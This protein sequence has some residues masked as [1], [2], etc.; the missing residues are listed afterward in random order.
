[1]T[2]SRFKFLKPED[3]RKL[4]S[5]EFAPKLIAEGY[6][7]GRHI[8]KIKGVS[9]EFHDYR[10]YL[11]GDDTSLVDWKLYSRTDRHY[12]KT[13]NQETNTVC[14]IY[15]DSSA[16][17]G[18]GRKLTKL[19]YSS[20]FAA[21]LSYLVTKGNNVVSLQ[22]F[23]DA[24]RNFI[25][26]GNS[27]RHLQNLMNILE[28]NYPGNQTNL[29][30]ALRRSYPLLKLK[31]TLVI[32][33]DFLDDPASIFE[34]LS[35]YLHAGHKVFLFH[36]LDPEEVNLVPDGLT[37]F[38]DMETGSRVTVHSGNIKTDYRK[39]LQ[40][41]IDRLREISVRKKIDYSVVHTN[42]NYFQLLDKFTK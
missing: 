2:A 10:Q 26:P 23:D 22:I 42:T 20:F 39:Q 37:R 35:Q 15:L 24:I 9:T 4:A 8:S 28:N 25:P 38:V 31:G 12:I 36:V 30:E 11:P 19:E 14:Y 29:G 33:S 32:I 7:A 1:M 21:A 5:Y 16:S 34:S 27:S 18:F 6:L 13:F 17:M 41:H 40:E 3:I